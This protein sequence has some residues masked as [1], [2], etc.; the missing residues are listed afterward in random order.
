MLEQQGRVLML[1]DSFMGARII[2]SVDI[3]GISINKKGAISEMRH[4]ATLV[5]EFDCLFNRNFLTS[6]CLR[7]DL[8][9]CF[10]E[11]LIGCLVSNFYL[12][13]FNL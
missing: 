8:L 2:P 12:D 10:Q 7:K 3:Q 9:I 5:Y 6:I 1:D 13:S 11:F 4:R